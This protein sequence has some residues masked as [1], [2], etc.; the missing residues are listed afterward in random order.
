MARKQHADQSRTDLSGLYTEITDGC[1]AYQNQWIIDKSLVLL[2]N[3]HIPSVK[4]EIDFDSKGLNRALIPKAGSFDTSNKFGLFKKDFQIACPYDG[5]K[6]KVWFY[7]RLV[8]DGPI[9]T[10]PSQAT[11]IVDKHVNTLRQQEERKC[12]INRI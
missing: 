3:A 5:Q 10:E 1:D 9:P 12:W 8:G 7:Y 2:I 11:D 4:K 6:R